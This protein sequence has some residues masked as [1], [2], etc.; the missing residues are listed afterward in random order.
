MDGE[1]SLVRPDG[2]LRRV[3][4]QRLRIQAPEGQTKQGGILLVT[5]LLLLTEK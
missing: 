2:A 3:R 4:K 1:F 5:F